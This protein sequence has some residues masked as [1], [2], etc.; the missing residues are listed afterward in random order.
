M[1]NIVSNP[2]FETNTAG[3]TLTKASRLPND[4]KNTVGCVTMTPD[5]GGAAVLSQALTTPGI[6]GVNAY[7]AKVSFAFKPTPGQPIKALAVTITDG[8][9]YVW[10]T[11][12]TGATQGGYVWHE[13]VGETIL[14]VSTALT[15]T[16]TVALGVDTSWW[17]IDDV[18][19]DIQAPGWAARPELIEELRRL[20]HDAVMVKHTLQRYQSA[21]NEALRTAPRKLWLTMIDDS[22]VTVADQVE[23]DLTTVSE[24]LQRDW[25]TRVDIE[26]S[27]GNAQPTARYEVLDSEGDLTLVLD[28]APTEDD[29]TIWLHFSLP[30]DPL[31]DDVTMTSCNRDWLIAKAMTILLLEADPQDE[32]EQWLATQLNMWDAKRKSHEARLGKRRPAGKAR[33]FNWGQYQ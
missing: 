7:D 14:P 12:T 27:D 24:L 28:T 20:R 5:A 18:C 29:L 17:R 1:T 32:G 13:V 8:S 25:L 26:D 30:H 16:F 10:Y 21:L 22:L 9:G 4:G 15:I 3:W 6:T 19:V 2:G 31:S 33:T 23:Y 11:Y